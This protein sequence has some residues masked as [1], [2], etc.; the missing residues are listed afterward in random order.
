MRNLRFGGWL[1]ASK[2]RRRK[3][4]DRA[5]ARF[6]ALESL[7]E[8]VMPV[9]TAKFSAGVL[10]VVG[11]RKSNTITVSSNAAGRLVVNNGAVKVQ[12]GR[13]TIAKV[14]LIQVNGKGG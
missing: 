9:V 8:R 10:T 7:D 4:R 14:K 12:G 11:D 6:F 2:D 13:P 3:R 5:A 1:G